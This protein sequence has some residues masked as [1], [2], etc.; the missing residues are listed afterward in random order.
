[1]DL[2]ELIN[3]FTSN[4][5]TAVLILIAVLII[6]VTAIVVITFGRAPRSPSIGVSTSAVGIEP[7]EEEE[8]SPPPKPLGSAGLSVLRKLSSLETVH[9]NSLVEELNLS[10]EELS[11]L[12]RDLREKG[13]I[14]ISYEYIVIT[15]KGRKYVELMEEKYSF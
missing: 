14:Q 13:L 4:L 11:E 3:L 7:G 15:D 8:R 6:S 1:M 9:Y 5:E 12:L 2:E 10:R